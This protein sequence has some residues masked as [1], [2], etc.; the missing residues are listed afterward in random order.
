MAI[1]IYAFYLVPILNIRIRDL[2][3]LCMIGFKLISRLA[4]HDMDFRTCVYGK[5]VKKITYGW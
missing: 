4:V 5:I 1:T 3:R 2:I